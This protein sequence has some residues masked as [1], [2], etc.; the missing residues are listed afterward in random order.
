[1]INYKLTTLLLF[2]LLAVLC[3]TSCKDDDCPDETNI[4]CPDYDPC[5]DKEPVFADFTMAKTA[6]ARVWLR[7]D[8][9]I[10]IPFAQKA[11]YGDVLFFAD[12]DAAAEY[13][14]QV[15]NNPENDRFT[16]SFSMRFPCTTVGDQIPVTL[17]VSRPGDTACVDWTQTTATMT[18]TLEIVSIEETIVRGSYRGHLLSKPDEVYTI[19]VE[20]LPCEEWY[21]TTTIDCFCDESVIVYHNLLNNGCT[22]DSGARY[23]DYN[24]M[25][26]HSFAFVD[27]SN[28]CD[29]PE[30]Y[31]RLQV[32]EA[33]LRLGNNDSIRVDM[34]FHYSGS[35]TQPLVRTIETFVGMRE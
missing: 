2:S 20:Y 23:A 8:S 26:G 22:I 6:R 11:S 21:T 5:W 34:D 33:L 7:S 3:Y 28:G 25:G 32:H 19:E 31:Q 9:F 24:F 27:A 1:M 14:W 16:A 15:G 29:L 12:D 35:A 10:V 4:S 13:H 30:D 18:K 17:T